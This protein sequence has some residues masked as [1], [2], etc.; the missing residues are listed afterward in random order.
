MPKRQKKL[1]RDRRLKKTKKNVG[2]RGLSAH[3]LLRGG[4]KPSTKPRISVRGERI[5]TW[6]GGGQGVRTARPRK[7]ILTSPGMGG[8]GQAENRD[9]FKKL[10]REREKEKPLNLNPPKK[11]KYT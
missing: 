3:L 6:R 9:G 2:I 11:A 10:F 7:E 1:T 5:V 8:D 4:K